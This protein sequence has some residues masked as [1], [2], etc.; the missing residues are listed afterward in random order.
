MSTASKLT[1]GLTCAVTVSIIY[2]VHYNQVRDRQK[3]H[4]GVIR[5]VAR[6]E[7]RRAEN[8][9]D[10]QLQQELTKEYRRAEGKAQQAASA[11]IH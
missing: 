4:E 8:L 1:L 11:G 10:L 9:K 2:S 3:L 7:R 6:Q 5:D